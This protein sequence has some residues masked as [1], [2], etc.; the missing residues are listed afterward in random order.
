MNIRISLKI[1]S[2]NSFKFYD[3]FK[4][5]LSQFLG[6]ENIFLYVKFQNI[7]YFDISMD[8]M[9]CFEK[10]LICE[11]HAR[12]V[13]LYHISFTIVIIIKLFH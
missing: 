13:L 6:V 4:L 11:N 2:D 1:F 12:K 3:E 10:Y 9:V 8:K 5:E 7:Y